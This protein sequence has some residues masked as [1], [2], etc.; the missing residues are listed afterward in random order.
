MV[1]GTS[2]VVI[3]IID[4]GLDLEHQDLSSQLWVNPGEIPGNGIDDDNNGFVD[5]INGWNFV[6]GSNDVYDD[7]GHGTLV[8]GVA[9]AASNN[10]QGIAGVCWNCRLMV[11]KAMQAS[12]IAN[13]SDIAAAVAYAAGK[14]ARVINLSLG[15]YSDSATLRAAIDA[16]SVTAVVVGGAGNDNLSTPFY[17][18]AYAKVLGVAGTTITDTKA[19]FSDYGSWVKVAA[20]GAGIT[21]TFLGGDWGSSSGTSL[22]APFVAGLAGLLVSEHPDWTPALVRSQILHTASSLAT[23]DPEYGSRLGAGM[24]NGGLAVQPPKPLI[25][26]GSFALNGTASG[27]P[28][29]NS[30]NSLV[31]SLWNDWLDATNVTGKLTTTDPFIAIVSDTS[32]FGTIASGE[33]KEGA[34]LSLTLAGAGYGRSMLFTFT[35]SANGGAYSAT[36]P[37]TITSRSSE[38]PVCGTLLDENDPENVNLV[39]TN[40]KTYVA[41]CNIGIALGYTL[42]I[43]PGTV[44]QFAGNYALSVGGTLIADG[45]TDRPIVFVS[46]AITGTWRSINFTDTSIDAQADVDGNYQSGNILRHVAIQGSAGGV[47]C[48]KATPFLSHVMANGGGVNCEVGLTP[49][50]LQESDLTGSIRFTGTMKLSTLPTSLSGFATFVENGT[51]YHVSAD[52]LLI[53]DVSDPM[54]P[55][56]LGTYTVP[57]PNWAADV[58]VVGHYAF[59]D[60]N[61]LRVVDV[62]NKAHPIEVGSLSA[63]AGPLVAAGNY[64]YTTGF[65]GVV[66]VCVLDVSDPLNPTK[67]GFYPEPSGANGLALA[68]RYLFLASGQSGLRIVDVFNPQNPVQVG[69]FDMAGDARS[70]AVSGTLAFVADSVHGM[71]V[72]DVSN[73][74][75]MIEI[76]SLDFGGFAIDVSIAS[77]FAYVADFFAGV[78]TIDIQD[79]RN[80]VEVAYFA[81]VNPRSVTTNNGVVFFADSNEGLVLYRQENELVSVVRTVVRNG[82]MYLPESSLAYGNRIDGAIAAGKSSIVSQCL[83]SGV[84]IVSG[85]VSN[86]VVRGGGIG[87]VSGGLVSDNDIESASGWGIAASGAVTIVHNR[88]VGNANGIRSDV[89]TISNNLI[90]NNAGVGLQVGAATVSNNSLIGNGGSAILVRDV[91]PV[92]I[93]GNNFEGNT[94]LYDIEVNI[95]GGVTISA[96]QNWWGLKSP[97]E[98]ARRLFDFSDD[99][100]LARVAYS[101]ILTLPA[102]SAPGYVRSVTISPDPVLGIQTGVFSIEF[103]RHMDMASNPRVAMSGGLPDEFYDSEWLSP[104]RYSV[105]YDF[106]ALI[107]KG[108]YILSVDGAMNVDGMPIAANSRYTITVD[109]AGSVADRTPPRTPGVTATGDGTLTNLFASWT[110]TD[111]ETAITQYRYGIGTSPGSRNVVDWTYVSSPNFARTGL[112]L[113]LGQVYYVVVGARNAGGLWSQSGISNKVI[114]GM[115]TVI[116]KAFF[117]FARR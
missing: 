91:L 23:S 1:T 69:T 34:P 44:I 107:T 49:T 85:I 117:P 63:C 15:G 30:S 67:V 54:H 115:A 46:K 76:G 59:V 50:W 64:V 52:G 94:G 86:S 18:A 79:P 62:S 39:W 36:F 61:G 83:S 112:N 92:K 20:P 13:Y 41:Q 104:S 56:Q 108:T 77:H 6:A 10:A 78:R 102:Q 17:P 3:A 57:G 11:V 29:P 99:Y 88:V 65:D 25:T 110:T 103:S 22:S 38:E 16:A 97:S 93:S 32:V 68:G 19:A 80:P 2:A 53:L 48:A 105:K 75:A 71:R 113:A 66:G 45:R 82:D 109:Y 24:V 43:Q 116:R 87:V 14:G 55:Y 58:V 37:L 27:R 70:V 89:G 7:N 74:G 98:I 21:T 8:G 111:T 106:T 81:G 31:V 5:D 114:G 12:G 51:A 42:T 96:Q 100:T 60:Y 26:F 90:A 33:V 40:D 72:I 84:E 47:T 95:A 28:D 4:S 73:P 101:P 35:V 9:G